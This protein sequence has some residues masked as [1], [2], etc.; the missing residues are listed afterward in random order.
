M[1]HFSKTA[2]LTLGLLVLSACGGDPLPIPPPA[3]VNPNPGILPIAGA[4][5]VPVSGVLPLNP[6]GQAYASTLTSS[7]G[8]GTSGG[9]LSSSIWYAQAPNAGA[10]IQN[11]VATATLTLQSVTQLMPTGLAG[12]PCV[13]TTDPKTGVSNPGRFANVGAVQMTMT[14]TIPVLSSYAG[15]STGTGYGYGGYSPYGYG[16]G[17][18]NTIQDTLT[19]RVGYSCD[20]WVSA[21]GRLY[22]CVDVST[23]YSG[24]YRSLYAQ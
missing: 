13:S 14:G 23:E 6:S 8:Y 7:Y 11:I 15:Y 16:G 17:Y 1:R 9:A 10:S 3:P 22:G 4:A 18:N 19:V 5:C 21:E 24:V 12:A 2:F 20:A